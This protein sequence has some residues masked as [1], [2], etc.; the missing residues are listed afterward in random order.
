MFSSGLHVVHIAAEMAPVAKVNFN[1]YY[2]NFNFPDLFVYN[3][4][5]MYV[6][7]MLICDFNISVVCSELFNIS[8]L[9]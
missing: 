4:H 3:I 6:F 8:T 9:H 2:T 1:L 5:Y 7:D